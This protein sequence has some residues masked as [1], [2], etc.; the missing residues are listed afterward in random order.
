MRNGLS[1]NNDDG[2]TYEKKN[3]YNRIKLLVKLTCIQY[4]IHFACCGY[5]NSFHFII[6]ITDLVSDESII[7]SMFEKEVT[8]LR[9]L[10]LCET[11]FLI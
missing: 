2:C 3:G 5:W 1:L 8:W 11:Y 10:C 4:Y 6:R 9:K 7:F